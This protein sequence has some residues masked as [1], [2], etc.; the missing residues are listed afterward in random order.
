MFGLEAPDMQI[1]LND[2]VR[3]LRERGN[4]PD[5]EPFDGVLDG[6]PV[7]LKTIHQT[8]K[9]PLFG[10]MCN[11]YRSDDVPVRQVIWPDR[12]GRWPWDDAA[13]VGCR[14]RQLRGWLPIDTH[15]SGGWRLV[16]ELAMDWPF[17]ELQPDT[18]VMASPEVVAGKLP[19]VA[20]THDDEGGWDFLDERG[21]ADEA[22]GWVHFGKLYHDYPWLSRFADLPLDTQAWLSPDG[23]WRRRPFGA[24]TMVES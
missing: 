24:A 23:Q 2:C 1:W 5:D 9:T 19:I 16:G 22:V 7:M 15:P 12:E 8:W 21:Y 14:E 6:F 13:S 18:T 10:S 17:G 3:V 11:Y 20:V 4:I